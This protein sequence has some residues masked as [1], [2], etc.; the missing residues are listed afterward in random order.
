V[1]Q[2]RLE[3]GRFRAPVMRSFHTIGIDLPLG[4]D[5]FD[6]FDGFEVRARTLA[7]RPSRSLWSISWNSSRIGKAGRSMMPSSPAPPGMPLGQ[8]CT[9]AQAAFRMSAILSPPRARITQCQ[10]ALQKARRQAALQNA[11]SS[12]PMSS[13]RSS[14]RT[15]RTRG[16]GASPVAAPPARHFYSHSMNLIPRLRER[17]PSYFDLLLW[18]LVARPFILVDGAARLKIAVV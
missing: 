6:G 7:A 14:P 2:P 12:R 18:V 13:A 9:F 5:G 8:M 16:H 11:A 15:G 10:A 17:P 3:C 4:R 1:S